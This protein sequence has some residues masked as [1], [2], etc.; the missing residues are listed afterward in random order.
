MFAQPTVSARGLHIFRHAATASAE[1]QE[2]V[3]TC[4]QLLPVLWAA[5]AAQTAAGERSFSDCLA[6]SDICTVPRRLRLRRTML[7]SCQLCAVS[8]TPADD[9]CDPLALQ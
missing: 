3:C 4:C 8:P 5:T 9:A 2:H 7:A 1:A 6:V